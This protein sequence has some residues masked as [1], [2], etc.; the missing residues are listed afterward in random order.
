MEGKIKT[1][2]LEDHIRLDGLLKEFQRLKQT[3]RTSAKKLFHEF[4]TGFVK[5][6]A[7]EEEILFPLIESRTS[8]HMPGPASITRNEHREI[9]KLLDKVYDEIMNKEEWTEELEAR[10]MEV[11]AAHGE[12]EDKVL[13]PWIEL[14]LGEHEK[15]E[16]LDKMK[17]SPAGNN[18]AR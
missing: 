10:L 12:E 16:A 8:L 7:W 11:M 9:R 15:E 3:D 13:Y 14:S 2:M 5:H 1:F 4:K 6:I 18:Q 17:T